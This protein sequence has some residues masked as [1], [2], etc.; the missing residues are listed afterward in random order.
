MQ[1]EKCWRP[2]TKSKMDYVW[3][4]KKVD[5]LIE[6]FK[7]WCNFEI[8]VKQIL[9]I[10]PELFK[11]QINHWFISTH[12]QFSSQI[13]YSLST[14]WFPWDCSMH[15]FFSTV[16]NCKSVPIVSRE[17]CRWPVHSSKP[18]I[19]GCVVYLRLAT[20]PPPSRKGHQVVVQGP[21]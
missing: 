18:M 3:K 1:R 20:L 5:G 13:F 12:Q 9:R 14:N 11:I 2:A 6:L 7:K 21:Q 10:T 8:Q 15:Y 4:C 17:T 19:P 16:T